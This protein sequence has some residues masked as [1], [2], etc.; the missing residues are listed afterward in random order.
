MA[1]WPVRIP[2]TRAVGGVSVFVQATSMETSNEDCKKK[3]RNE[4]NW[5]HVIWSEYVPIKVVR[6]SRE[7]KASSAC[8]ESCCCC[9]EAADG[10]RVVG[11]R[12]DS[13]DFD[14]LA[15]HAAR[16]APPRSVLLAEVP[17]EK[18]CCGRW[19]TFWCWEWIFHNVEACSAAWT[20]PFPPTNESH[21]QHNR[22]DGIFILAFEC[23]YLQAI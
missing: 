11:L 3:W 5:Q 20:A 15:P 9:C 6:E 18:T 1:N 2:Y 17:K 8:F 23:F 22:L 14:G 7:R 19:S 16:V 12:K 4:W 13:L 21:T 10:C